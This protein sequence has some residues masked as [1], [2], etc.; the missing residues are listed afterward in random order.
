MAA[1]QEGVDL[2]GRHAHDVALLGHQ[3]NLL[4]SSG[5]RPQSG[6]ASASVTTNSVAGGAN[7]TA[8]VNG[9][10]VAGH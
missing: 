9:S 6:L 10:A 4:S 3:L 5:A 8:A 7:D 1:V 2:F